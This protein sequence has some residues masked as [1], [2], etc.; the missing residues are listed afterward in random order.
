MKNR[1][2]ISFLISITLILLSSNKAYSQEKASG[3]SAAFVNIEEK[4]IRFDNRAK[5]L[6]KYLEKYDSPLAEHADVFV[7]EADKNKLD[8][9]LVASISGVESTFA[10][11]LPYNSYNAWGWGIYGDQTHS[12]DSY[13]DGIQTISKGIR[14]NYINKWGAKDVYQIGK[15]YA[16]SPTWAQK[17][18]YF[19]NRIDE[20]AVNNAR[21]SLPLTI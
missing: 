15:I 17:V 21:E 5:I 9:R 13:E 16:A 19:M 11:F 6:K 3:T 2:I 20:F 4:N 10:H 7:M 14:E 12:F 18:E 1:L 8:W